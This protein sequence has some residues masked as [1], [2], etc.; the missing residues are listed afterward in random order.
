MA[1]KRPRNDS[2]MAA[3]DA[4][5]LT[6]PAAAAAGGRAAAA[7]AGSSIS[8]ATFA[9]ASDASSF[10]QASLDGVLAVIRRLRVEAG[11]NDNFVEALST[12]RKMLS[13]ILHHPTDEKFRSVRIANKHF[14]ARVGRFQA[15]IDLLQCFGFEEAVRSSAD[16]STS[17]AA[18]A[19]SAAD[20][21]SGGHALAATHLALPVADPAKMA[22]GLVLLEAARQ[23]STMVSGVGD[24]DSSGAGTSDAPAGSA[25]TIH[26]SDTMSDERVTKRARSQHS[27]S[28]EAPITRGAPSAG[29]S[30][31]T[32]AMVGGAGQEE[33]GDDSFFVPPDLEDY[34]AAGIDQCLPRN[35]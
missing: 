9:A 21:V 23:A 20:G 10:S 30:A 35:H 8:A 1:D 22:P 14:Y 17:A 16:D 28:D 11:G 7:A 2:C 31:C 25:S 24:G 33:D 4:P 12:I 15:G 26:D 32:V 3:S 18:A 29:A 19:T 5:A 13:N 34:S 6:A 27:A